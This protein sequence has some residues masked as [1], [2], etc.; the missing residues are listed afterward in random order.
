MSQLVKYRK[1]RH[2][3]QEDLSN[4]SGVSVRTIQRIE[5]GVIP[6]G[7]TL[8]ALAKALEIDE[9]A[10][11]GEAIPVDCLNLKL[12]NLINISTLFVVFIPV[13]N[14]LVPLSIIALKKQWHPITKQ[15]ISIQILWALLII[16]LYLFFML[17]NLDELGRTIGIGSLWLL[18][19]LNVVVILRNSVELTKNNRLYFQLKFSFI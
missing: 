11:L 14:I 3:T 18:T 13:L 6:K 9:A 17:L 15:I 7:F 2:L 1:E 5:S 10:L 19:I 12:C 8:K 4:K 16:G